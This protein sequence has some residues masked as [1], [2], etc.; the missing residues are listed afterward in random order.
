MAI[1]KKAQ[2]KKGVKSAKRPLY[3]WS[4]KEDQTMLNISNTTIDNALYRPIPSMPTSIKSNVVIGKES[5]EGMMAGIKVA[6]DAIRLSY[7]PHG[8]NAVVENEFYPF[9]QVCNDAQTI[10]QAIEV[11]HPIQK[12]GLAFLKELSDK[13]NKDSGDGRKTTCILAEEILKGALASGLSGM[14]LKRDLDALIPVIE[15]KINE[16]KRTITEKEVG[17]VATIAGESEEIGSIIQAIYEQIGKDGIIIPEGSGTF[18]TSFSVIEGVRFA[19][20]GYL[21]PYMVHDEQALKDGQRETKAVYENPTILVTKRKITHLNDINPL[22]EVMTKQGKK[23]LVIFTDDMDSGVASILV[24]AHQDKVLNVL[25]IK[26]PVLFKN[27]VFEDFARITGSTIVEDASGINYKNLSL[28]H[29][30][31]C[32]KIVVDKD[33]TVVTGIKDISDHLTDLRSRDDD[34]SKLRLSWLCTKTAI[35]KIGANNES[36]LS[37]KRLKCYD[38]ISSS[39]LALKDGVVA[40]GGLAL[41]RISTD[42]WRNEIVAKALD[43][44]YQQIIKNNGNQIESIDENVIMDSAAVVKNAVRNAISLASTIL[45]SQ[46]VITLPPKP[47]KEDNKFPFK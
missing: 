29:L 33:E 28:N 34:E 10:I 31:T 46:I 8:V 16:Q 19:D 38:A 35:L 5:V 15:R 47:A 44:P 7:G 40:G 25:I 4:G 27:A 22:L 12:R 13:A 45:T 21:S 18:Q 42:L 14:E 11:T 36:E 41:H 39:G 3:S 30:G 32:G 17:S 43:A 1:K 37:Y 24:K 6:T 2:S 23:D 9:H 26:A 20:T